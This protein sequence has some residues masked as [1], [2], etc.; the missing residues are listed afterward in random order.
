MKLLEHRTVLELLQ[1]WAFWLGIT[2]LI[3]GVLPLLLHGILHPGTITLCV[4]GGF[5]LVLALGE[6]FWGKF[7]W[8]KKAETVGFW[9]AGAGV[10]IA[11][12]LTLWMAKAAW[13]S[14]PPRVEDT[15]LVVLGCGISEDRPTLMLQRRLDAAYLQLKEHPELKCILSGGQGEDEICPESQVMYQYLLDKGIPPEQLIEENISRNT[16]E[17]LA[18]SKELISIQGLPAAITIVTDDYHQRRAALYA[19]AIGFEEIYHISGIPSVGLLP[20]YMVREF[21]GFA[22][23][24]LLEAS[25]F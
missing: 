17:N 16:R 12:L 11:L 13:F 1:P 19:K 4:G 20:S 18:F 10:L 22:K 9:I 6:A 24:F 14:R 23:F 3:F 7:S 5:L 15:T 21:F 8:W 25:T 2:L